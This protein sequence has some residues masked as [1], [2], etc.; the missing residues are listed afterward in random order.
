[1][2]WLAYGFTV[3][4]GGTSAVILR[5]VKRAFWSRAPKGELEI[6]TRQGAASLARYNDQFSKTLATAN[7]SLEREKIAVAP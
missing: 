3:I 6:R 4:V 2:F 1:M 5:V 7:R